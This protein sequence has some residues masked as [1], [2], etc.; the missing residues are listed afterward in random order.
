MI[1]IDMEMPEN[2]LRCP[3]QFGG[4]CYVRPPEVDE[5]V[6]P[7]VDEAWERGKPDWCPLVEVPDINVGKCSEIPNC[8]DCISRRTAIEKL[9]REFNETDVP[10][11]YPGVFD[12]I[13][14]WLSE[15]ELPSVHPELDEWCTTCKEYD[16]EKHC[17]PRFNRVIRETVQ[18]IQAERKKGKWLLSDEQ[19]REDTDNGNYL[20]FCSN[21]LRSDVHAKT[22]EVPY[23]WWCGADMRGE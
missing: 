3:M 1:Q 5:R 7:T 10:D 16:H 2:C 22:Q 19:R 17:C 8:S 20:Y 6:A 21:C 15:C 11:R 13:E 18:E 9:K 14:E 4:W 12:A 23:C